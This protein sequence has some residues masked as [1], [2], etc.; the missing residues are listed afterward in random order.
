AILDEDRLMQE[1]VH[2]IEEVIVADRY[3]VLLKGQTNNNYYPK[4]IRRKDEGRS[5]MPLAISQNMIR[6]VIDKGRGIIFSVNSHDQPPHPTESMLIYGIQS[7]MCSPIVTKDHL[8]GMVYLD[9]FSKRDQFSEDDLR[10]LTAMAQQVGVALDNVRLYE[11]VRVQERVKQELQIARR[12]QRIQLPSEFPEIA[13]LDVSFKNITAEEVGGD[14]YDYYWL[15]DHHVGVVIADVSGKGVPGALVITMFRSLLKSHVKRTAKPAKVLMEVN[16]L[17]HSDIERDAFVTAIYGVMDIHQ[18][19]FVFTR[20]GHVPLIILRRDGARIEQY[21]PKGM[22]LGMSLWDNLNNLEDMEIM[23]YPGDA[24]VLY[25]DGIIEAENTLGQQY[26]IDRFLETIRQTVFVDYP[27]ANAKT[28]LD[29]MLLRVNN[30]IQ[31]CSLKDDMTL[32][33]IK[34]G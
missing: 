7:A 18:K 4:I 12:I 13:A 33:I 3:V 34:I 29:H 27:E 10:L 22:M 9:S 26:G 16:N 31:D 17:L 19:K 28:L 6:E 20:A 32:G 1:M 8:F 11:E 2:L 14:Y 23:L 25:T 24:I 5:Y 15:D 21:Q 30:F